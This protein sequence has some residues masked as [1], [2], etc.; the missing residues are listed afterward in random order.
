MVLGSLG[1]SVKHP[2]WVT[3]TQDLSIPFSAQGCDPSPSSWPLPTQQRLKKTCRFCWTLWA[4]A[5]PSTR[6]KS[7]KASLSCCHAPPPEP[8]SWLCR[9]SWSCRWAVGL[10]GGEGQCQLPRLSWASPLGVGGCPVQPLC[11]EKDSLEY[12]QD[13]PCHSARFPPGRGGRGAL[14]PCGARAGRAVLGA[15]GG[16][17]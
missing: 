10:A 16:P 13:H 2:R 8:S 1:V 15:P 4:M 11:L 6:T 5:I 17:V 14:H 9:R 3:Q 7:T 12:C